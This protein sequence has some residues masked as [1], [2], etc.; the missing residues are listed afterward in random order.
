VRASDRAIHAARRLIAPFRPIL[1]RSRPFSVVWGLERGTPIDRAYIERFLSAHR[2]DIGGRVL[3]VKDTRYTDRFGTG[4]VQ[5]DVL[6]VDAANPLATIVADLSTADRVPSDAFDCFVLTQTLQFVPDPVGAVRHAHRLLRPNGVLLASVPSI[7][8]VEGRAHRIDRWRYTEA[9]CRDLFEG[10]FDPSRVEISTA[11]N[12]AAAVAF[13]M[14]MAA[15]E[16]KAG[17][18]AQVDPDFP[19]VVLV[20]AVK[21]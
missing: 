5:K 11:G 15:E 2:S 12:V 16:L 3:E 7:T 4:V 1:Y 20:R 17:R 9:S 19:V 6:D 21:S 13:L 8:K 14:G 18:L 10:V